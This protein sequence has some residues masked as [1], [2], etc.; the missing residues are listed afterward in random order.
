MWHKDTRYKA[1]DKAW[2][3][4]N[5]LT[6]LFLFNRS[7]LKYFFR[8]YFGINKKIPL[9]HKLVSIMP[10]HFKAHIKDNQFASSFYTYDRMSFKVYKALKYVWL[11]IHF[12][13]MKI[14]NRFFPRFNLGYDALE[15]NGGEL[16]VAGT[17][18]CGGQN[19]EAYTYYWTN[20]RTGVAGDM[21]AATV[22]FGG[23]IQMLVTLTCNRPTSSQNRYNL[24]QRGVMSFN[25]SLLDD[26]GIYIVSAQIGVFLSSP[27]N[28]FSNFPNDNLVLTSHEKITSY[29]LDNNDLTTADYPYDQFGTTV[30]AEITWDYY[31]ANPGYHVFELNPAGCNYI[32][33]TSHTAFGLMLKFDMEDD[34]PPYPAELFDNTRYAMLI[35]PDVTID[36]I[37]NEI[38]YNIVMIQ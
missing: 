6:L 18:S 11:S 27:S 36:V 20:I 13:D 10:D 8:Q 29:V 5:Q 2:F 33:K 15:F 7:W 12:W 24:L 19:Y 31:I 35:D 14:A 9:C 21:G 3:V 34:E 38:G 23:D 4:R 16:V 37:Y 17:V 26:E 1:F 28:E 30:F 25:T 32:K 22:Y